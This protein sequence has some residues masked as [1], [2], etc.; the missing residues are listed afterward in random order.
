MQKE[1]SFD[2]SYF[3]DVNAQKKIPWVWIILII[4]VVAFFVWRR[5]KKKKREKERMKKRGMM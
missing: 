4:A 2:S 3:T 1:V 5:M